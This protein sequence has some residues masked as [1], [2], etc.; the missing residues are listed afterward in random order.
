MTLGAYQID[1]N[2]SKGSMEPNWVNGLIVRFLIYVYF[3]MEQG[4]QV[5]MLL[6]VILLL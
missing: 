5:K 2:R 6:L 3:V 1:T 4:V